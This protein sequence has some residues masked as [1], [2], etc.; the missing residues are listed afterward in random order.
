MSYQ[1]R[2]IQA[3]EPQEQQQQQQGSEYGTYNGNSN[4]YPPSQQQQQYPQYPIYQ[5]PAAGYPSDAAAAAAAAAAGQPIYWAQDPAMMTIPPPV[6][7]KSPFSDK[8]AGS[9]VGT[10]VPSSGYPHSLP[11]RTLPSQNQGPRICGV[12]RNSFYILVAVAC[13]LL[14]LG[15]ATGVGVGLAMNHSTPR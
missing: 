13:F 8:Y 15:I 10:D 11:A 3:Q 6:P 1:L 2:P 12:K 9:N 7:P 4:V 5:W 14:V